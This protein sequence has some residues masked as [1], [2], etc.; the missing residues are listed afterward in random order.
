ME[1]KASPSLVGDRLYLPGSKGVMVVAAAGP[2]FKEQA[3]SDLADEIAAS[4]AFLDGS[5]LIRSK[6]HLWRFGAKKN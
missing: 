6:Q 5:I 2:E 1:F 4:P 3:R